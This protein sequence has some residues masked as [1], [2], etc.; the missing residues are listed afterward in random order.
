MSRRL[1]KH[2]LKIEPLA[3]F[4]ADIEPWTASKRLVRARGWRDH[5]GRVRRV[6]AEFDDGWTM[7][8]TITA[9]GMM[10]TEAVKRFRFKVHGGAL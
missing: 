4:L 2:E 6:A 5:A 3:A 9:K 7:R 10:T 8:L 1:T